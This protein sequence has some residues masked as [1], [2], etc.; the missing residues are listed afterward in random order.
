MAFRRRHDARSSKDP[1]LVLL[2]LVLLVH[3][4]PIRSR[5]SSRNRLRRSIGSSRNVNGS[6]HTVFRRRGSLVL[7]LVSL[8][9]F[10]LDLSFEGVSRTQK[11][12][13]YPS[14]RL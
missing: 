8:S 13:L 10:V 3:S 12:V 2:R 4:K 9:V 11:V 7:G 6:G 1:L 14:D 5:R